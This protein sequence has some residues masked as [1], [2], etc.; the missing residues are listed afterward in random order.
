MKTL[1]KTWSELYRAFARCAAVVATAEE[2]LCC[3]ELSSKIMCSLED[4]ALSVS[5][6]FFL[7]ITLKNLT[8]Y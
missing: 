3:E 6:F 7:K 2:N 8:V 1:L 5:T 4:E